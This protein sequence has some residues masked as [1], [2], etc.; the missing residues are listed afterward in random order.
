MLSGDF[1][2][3]VVHPVD[4]AGAGFPLIAQDLL[5]FDLGQTWG[6]PSAHELQTRRGSFGSAGGRCGG[7]LL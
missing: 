1:A 3:P 7:I 2:L 6:Q 5:E 4:L